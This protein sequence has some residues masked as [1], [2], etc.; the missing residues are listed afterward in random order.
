MAMLAWLKLTPPVIDLARKS[1]GKRSMM[2]SRGI[3]NSDM[4]AVAAGW[5]GAGAT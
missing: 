5:S 4:F 3:S 2:G 1:A